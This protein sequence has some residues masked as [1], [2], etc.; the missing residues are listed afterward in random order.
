MN[1]SHRKLKIKEAALGILAN[2]VMGSNL[3]TQVVLNCES[4]LSFLL[5]FLKHPKKRI[6]IL[7]CIIISNI[8]AGPTDHIQTL[9]NAGV[10][11]PLVTILKSGAVDLQIEA[12]WAICNATYGHAEQIRCDMTT[13]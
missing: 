5:R 1:A 7:T 13:L 6:R 3:L 4:L 11:G 2:I 9:I 12:A 8:M 10:I